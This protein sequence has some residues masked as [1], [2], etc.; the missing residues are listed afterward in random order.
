MKSNSNLY[1]I[2]SLSTICL[3]AASSV[4]SVPNYIAG[5]SAKD[6][7]IRNEHVN[8]IAPASMNSGLANQLMRGLPLQFEPNEGQA[9]S[10]FDFLSRGRGYSVQFNSAEA[11]FAL[12]T[13]TVKSTPP[14]GKQTISLQQ[15]TMRLVNANLTKGV[16]QQALPGRVN[17]FSGSDPRRFHTNI[18]TYG[19][20]RYARVYP[21]IDVVYYGKQRQL[22]HDFIVA[23]EANADQ[24]KLRFEAA[25]AVKLNAA[26]GVT[27]S[28]GASV[29]NLE[30]PVAYQIVNGERRVVA[31]SYTLNSDNSIG[32]KL[33]QYDHER[34]LV[35][36]PVLFYSSFL[37]GSAA[38]AANDI[39]LDPAGNIY[40][41]GGTTSA[42]FP[43]T[44]GSASK[45]SFDVF[46]TKLNPT[47]T[48]IIFSTLLASSGNDSGLSIGLDSNRN[49]YVSGLT[50]N[51]GFPL[52][53]GAFQTTHSNQDGFAAKLNSTG[54][55]LLYSTLLG[56]SPQINNG[57][58]MVVDQAGDMYL[59]GSTYA[60]NFPTTSNAFRQTVN[61]FTGTNF[62]SSTDSYVAKIHPAGAGAADLVYSTYLGGNLGD[63]SARITLDSA[64]FVYVTGYTQSTNF[65]TT[66]DALQP[67]PTTT[68]A[69]IRNGNDIG[70][71]FLV[72]MDLSKSGAA[73]MVY[74]TYIGGTGRDVAR[75]VALDPAKNVYL[76]GR[77][78]SGNFP[79]SATAL[80][81]HSAGGTDVYVMK[82]NL[83]RPG[84]SGLIYS[85]YLGGS[86]DEDQFGGGIAV[87]SV[88][89]AFV[90][91][92]TRST[93]L[94]VTVGAFQPSNGGNSDVFSAP[95]GDAF[96]AKLNSA[97]TALVYFTYLGGSGGDNASAIRLDAKGN[98]YLV[99]YTFSPNFPL[100]P[101]ALQT[102][103]AGQF[104]AFVACIDVP[105]SFGHSGVPAV[106]K[107]N[108]ETLAD[109]LPNPID[110]AQKF[111]RQQYIDFLNREPDAPGLSFWTNEITSCGTDPVCISLKRINVSGA[112]F[113]SIEFQQ[114]GYLVYR[115]YL[116][117]FAR[118]PRLNEFSPDTRVIRDSVIVNSPGWEQ[119]L[120]NNTQ[121]FMLAFVQRSDFLSAFP[122][123]LTADQFVSQLDVNAGGVLSPSEKSQ[124]VAVLGATPADPAKR[125]SV[126]RSVASDTTLRD[127][128]FN[129][130]FVLMQYYG[131]LQRNPDD[132]PDTDNSGYIFWLGKLDDFNGNFVKA[133][134]VKAFISSGEYR[135]RFGQN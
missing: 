43:R 89:N 70:D 36:D 4:L 28:A 87:D 125:A 40:I 123:S 53:A 126:L 112:F 119:A 90:V 9:E 129:K 74:A 25:D 64:G 19:G 46:I 44:D 106:Q 81:S 37:G 113:L 38:D 83:S 58:R 128:E 20:V 109:A 73:S 5:S 35:I 33:G 63:E 21:G 127:R 57:A 131:Y 77:T 78:D 11:V 98:A 61:P 54:S 49:V 92:D 34:Q 85:T 27:I 59:T 101:N 118:I 68:D 88:G 99:G 41:T 97:G 107:E 76:T 48:A 115:T 134:M 55:A 16:G 120:E 132:P 14:S 82:L 15:V 121:A 93:N 12:Q 79:V 42:E 103:Q 10:R 45:G 8:R 23:P 111:V 110:E 51:A 130:A 67:F 47:G 39:A 3:L 100:S 7:N 117:A 72:K 124:L 80:Q 13:S 32:F 71:A 2:S 17:Y 105:S 96:A 52:T 84:T 56:G 22:E 60:S 86:A 133:D 31:S 75:G 122:A 104:D 26:G 116:S 62:L 91:G 18:R 6:P 114:T 69:G 30:K 65:P 50:D 1:K 102:T 66:A 135:T 29:M 95:G 94:P 24:I 108:S